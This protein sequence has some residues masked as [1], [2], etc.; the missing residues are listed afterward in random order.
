M[1]KYQTSLKNAI[2]FQA[3]ANLIANLA[4]FEQEGC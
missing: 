2:D 4:A 3:V 1:K